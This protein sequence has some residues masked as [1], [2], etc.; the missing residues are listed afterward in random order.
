MQRLLRITAVALAGL[1]L[2][3]AVYF[4]CQQATAPPDPSPPPQTAISIDGPDQVKPNRYAQLFIKGATVEQLVGGKLIEYPRDGVQCI[5]AMTWSGEPFV[6]VAAEDPGTYLIAVAAPGETVSYAEKEITVGDANPEPGPDENPYPAPSPA[7]RA[8]VEP[9]RSLTLPRQASEQIGL[10][11]AAAAEAARADNALSSTA[12][13]RGFLIDSGKAL[14][15]TGS[16]PEMAAAHD[17]VLAATLTLENRPLDRAN[18]AAVL[19]A[20]AWA[21]W[22]AGH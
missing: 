14:G 10:W 9:I 13:L 6:L 21:A 15:L 3:L 16:L 2:S 19:E 18:A 12:D 1:C 17:Q 4:G 22:E 5:P 11:Y 7:W 8:A 20:M